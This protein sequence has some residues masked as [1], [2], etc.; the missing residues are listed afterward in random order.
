MHDIDFISRSKPEIRHVEIVA[1]SRLFRVERLDLRFSNGREVQFERLASSSRG[2]VLVLPF[3]DP[4]TML[5]VREYGAGV[6]RYELGFP[7]GRIEE[8]ETAATT[9]NREI[10]EEIGYGSRKLTPLKSLSLA[11]GYFSHRTEVI[12]AEELYA[13]HIPG[14]EPE[15]LEVVPWPVAKFQEL[16][17][18]EDFTEARSIAA[19]YLA[20][21]MI[22]K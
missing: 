13:A 12:L 10:M 7:K 20:T 16:L 4:D 11:P 18:R 15:D 8:G 3:V 22:H 21:T 9:A 6:D 5:L 14:D 17:A 1:Q 2:A 19:L